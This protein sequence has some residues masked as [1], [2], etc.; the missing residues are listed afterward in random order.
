MPI[1]F[2]DRGLRI[3]GCNVPGVSFYD[4]DGV[5]WHQIYLRED[6]TLNVGGTIAETAGTAPPPETATVNTAA[7]YI[8]TGA[9]SFMHTITA[10]DIVPQTADTYD[11]GAAG[12][13][14]RK[15]YISE[16]ETTMF[17]SNAIVVSG[18]RQV[19]GHNAGVLAAHLSDAADTCDFGIAMTPGD[20]VEMRGYGQVEY[21]EVGDNVVGTVYKIGADGS[22]AR[23][24]DGSGANTWPSGTP[25]LVLGPA[26]MGG[27]RLMRTG[28]ASASSSRA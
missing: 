21:F 10:Q 13:L 4:D 1:E 11:L 23:D 17:T 6:N 24:L 15:A 19:W 14:W 22:G 16:L 2:D 7:P 5:L 8:W 18:A 27:W 25:F 12:N 9:H 28:R 3:V 26:A 20:F